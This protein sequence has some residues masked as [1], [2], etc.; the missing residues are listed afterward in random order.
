MF[1]WEDKRLAHAVEWLKGQYWAIGPKQAPIE[2]FSPQTCQHTERSWDKRS[3][4]LRHDAKGCLQYADGMKKRNDYY[5]QEWVR[6]E[7]CQM[8]DCLS[9]GFDLLV[10]YPVPPYRLVAFGLAQK[11][12]EKSRLVVMPCPK[13]HRVMDA[14]QTVNGDSGPQERVEATQP[15]PPEVKPAVELS[16]FT[17]QDCNATFTDRWECLKHTKEN[18]IKGPGRHKAIR[19]ALGAL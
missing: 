12:A 19:Q 11:A 18:H 4:G 1:E 7:K 2:T 15:S 6:L 9:T 13:C 5:F 8:D 16:P 17:C 10:A 14:F 3:K